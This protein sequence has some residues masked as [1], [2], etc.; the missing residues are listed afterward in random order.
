MV[1][2]RPRERL[3]ELLRGFSDAPFE[4]V[5]SSVGADAHG[6]LTYQRFREALRSVARYLPRKAGPQP[7]ISRLRWS[8]LRCLGGMQLA[9]GASLDGKVEGERWNGRPMS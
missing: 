2:A 6:M 7:G 3:Q 9:G 4:D 8:H 5:M 1:R